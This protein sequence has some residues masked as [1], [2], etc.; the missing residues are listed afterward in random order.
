MRFSEPTVRLPD[1]EQLPRTVMDKVPRHIR[2]HG[3]WT[4]RRQPSVMETPE[5]NRQIDAL[6]F[7]SEGEGARAAKAQRAID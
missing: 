2:K 1:S 4:A 6:R 3:R 7:L 5:L